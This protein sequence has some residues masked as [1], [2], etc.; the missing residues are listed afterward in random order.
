MLPAP[1]RLKFFQT[2]YDGYKH[3]FESV[4]EKTENDEI[5]LNK[6]FLARMLARDASK[7]IDAFNAKAGAN[8]QYG[9]RQYDMKKVIRLRM[10]E[11]AEWPYIPFYE[12]KSAFKK[13]NQKQ[14]H[15]FYY[16]LNI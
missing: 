7:V 4:E 11:Y 15:D 16:K 2:Y 13:L 12:P 5:A 6:K 10:V 14:I 3:F 9:F 1:E 8:F